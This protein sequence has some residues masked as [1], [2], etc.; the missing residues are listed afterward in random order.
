MLGYFVLS[1]DRESGGVAGQ[2]FRL[3]VRSGASF[4][5]QLAASAAVPVSHLALGTRAVGLG[6]ATAVFYTE[7]LL[8]S[9]LAT[10]HMWL[11]C[12]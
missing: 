1:R 3:R 2:P 5:C 12:P 6:V 9:T 4:G 7:S 10:S 11:L 8:P